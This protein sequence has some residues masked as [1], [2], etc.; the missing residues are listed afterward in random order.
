[1]KIWS[2]DGLRSNKEEEY[3]CHLKRTQALMITSERDLKTAEYPY[4]KVST[5]Q[6]TTFLRSPVD[7]RAMLRMLDL[8]FSRL[9][10]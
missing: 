4:L 3:P 5:G 6:R 8:S 2:E 7:G 1:M 9:W 10:L